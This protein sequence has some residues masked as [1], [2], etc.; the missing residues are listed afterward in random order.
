MS[1]GAIGTSAMVQSAADG[2]QQSAVRNPKSAIPNPESAIR[3]PQS[4]IDKGLAFLAA[5]Q[6]PDG[7]WEA[8]ER[9]H[10]AITAL[11]VKCFLQ[12][13]DYGPT[14]PIVRRA[15][16]FL[17]RYVQPDGGI[18]VPGEGMR[19]YHTSVALMALAATKDAA[20]AE[21]IK[22]AQTFLKKLQWDSGE[23]HETSSSWYGG[24]GYGQHKRP[25]LSNTQMMLDALK[26][27]G[28]S[29]DDP[30]YRKAMVFIERC[31]MLGEKND[32]TFADESVDGGFIYTPVAGGESKAGIEMVDGKPRLRSYGSMTYAGFKSMLYADVDR[33]D[34]RVQRALDWIRRY[35]TL[36]HNPNMPHAQ[37]KQG[38]YYYYHVFARALHA[39]GEP[40]LVDA[41]G[42]PHR[43]GEELCERLV[44]LQRPEGLWVNEE[45]RWYEG[46]PHLVT[47]Y[48]ILA[49][50]T[51]LNEPQGVLA[52][53]E[54]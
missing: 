43:W 42:V 18:Y 25:D 44:S 48:A 46:N 34:V 41:Q 36:D 13:A 12:D 53:G 4:A 8:F 31:Q 29:A 26:Q 30:V 28:L 45:D 20:H 47:A 24:Q 10:P 15:L 50:Q 39:W 23:G 37:S 7:G 22:N 38:L 11:V 54:G 21:K 9:S 3:N 14:H 40:V 1:A 35:Y 16:G 17:L 19:N 5:S 6:R 33:N 49:L 27:S 2:D 52:P 51:A 32:Q